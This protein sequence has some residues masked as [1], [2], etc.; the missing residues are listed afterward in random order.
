VPARAGFHGAGRLKTAPRL[1]PPVSTGGLSAAAQRL[2]IVRV[3]T[4]GGRR[5]AGVATYSNRTKSNTGETAT[6]PRRRIFPAGR[7]ATHPRSTAGR[8]GPS[9]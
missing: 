2:R 4:D 7:E 6:A 3:S 8:G 1:P 5:G 9:R